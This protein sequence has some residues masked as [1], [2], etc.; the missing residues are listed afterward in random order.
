MTSALI[1]LG[2]FLLVDILVASSITLCL[3]NRNRWL[4]EHCVFFL[5]NYFFRI[6]SQKRHFGFKGYER[7]FVTLR[8]ASLLSHWVVPVL[9]CFSSLLRITDFHSLDGLLT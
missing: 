3:T 8:V 4:H 6:S 9:N 1:S 5:L 7:L 2:L